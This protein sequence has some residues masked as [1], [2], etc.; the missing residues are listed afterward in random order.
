MRN[1]LWGGGSLFG[2]LD[3]NHTENKTII[4]IG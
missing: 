4:D 2:G 3:E 1:C